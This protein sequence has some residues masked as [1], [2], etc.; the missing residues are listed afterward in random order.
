MPIKGQSGAIQQNPEAVSPE[1]LTG[2]A[3]VPAL[4]VQVLPSLVNL[5]FDVPHLSCRFPPLFLSSL[6]R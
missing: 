1:S 6:L 3:V 2:A 5:A 4:S